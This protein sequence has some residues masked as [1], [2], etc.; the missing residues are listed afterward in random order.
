MKYIIYSMVRA[1]ASNHHFF[2]LRLKSRIKKKGKEMYIHTELE[3]NDLQ[4]TSVICTMITTL[5]SQNPY[6]LQNF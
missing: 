1:Y 2:E 4:T 6:N 3:C 5:L